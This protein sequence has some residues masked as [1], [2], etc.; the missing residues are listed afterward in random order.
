MNSFRFEARQLKRTKN[1]WPASPSAWA[2]TLAALLAILVRA[3]I[4]AEPLEF[5]GY[6]HLN[7]QHLFLLTDRAVGHSSGWLKTGT[8][9]GGYLVESFEPRTE[10]LTVRSAGQS[11]ALSL[12]QGK[13]QDGP[14]RTPPLLTYQLSSKG[15]IE[16]ETFKR[17]LAGVSGSPTRVKI[18]LQSASGTSATQLGKMA[19]V[20]TRVAKEMKIEIAEMRL[21]VR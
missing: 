20:A 17:L 10:I 21:E 12:K 9:F 19:E 15:E 13:V 2:A 1:G 6:M 5:S 14:V 4:A 16:V 18:I 7:N 11:F 8:S 3:S